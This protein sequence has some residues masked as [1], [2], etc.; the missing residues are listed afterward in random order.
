MGRGVSPVPGLQQGQWQRF[1]FIRFTFYWMRH[2]RSKKEQRVLSPGNVKE[3]LH[4]LYTWQPGKSDEITSEQRS[5]LTEGSCDPQQLPGAGGFETE[6]I[7]G[8]TVNSR[9]TRRRVRWDHLLRSTL[10]PMMDVTLLESP[11]ESV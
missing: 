4:S 1:L 2:K 7:V 8:P 6:S 9:D 11:P 10:N 5:E 3:C